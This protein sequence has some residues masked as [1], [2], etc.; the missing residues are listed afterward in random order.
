MNLDVTT[1]AALCEFHSVVKCNDTRDALLMFS[2][3]NSSYCKLFFDIWKVKYW[4][5][6]LKRV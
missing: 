4:R 6:V 2:M 5:H 1:S 3:K